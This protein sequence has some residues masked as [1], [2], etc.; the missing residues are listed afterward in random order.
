MQCAHTF[1]KKFC[2]ELF[3]VNTKGCYLL[4]CFASNSEFSAKG[5]GVHCEKLGQGRGDKLLNHRGS[6]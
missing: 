3:L 1:W 2:C 5:G 4:F 6:P